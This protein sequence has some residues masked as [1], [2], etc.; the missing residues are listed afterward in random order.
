MIGITQWNFL[1]FN[2]FP[3][4]LMF[5]GTPLAFLDDTTDKPPHNDCTDENSMAVIQR[6]TVTNSELPTLTLSEGKFPHKLPF[7]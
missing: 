1:Y 6:H 5:L 7:L 2:I 3:H 4:L